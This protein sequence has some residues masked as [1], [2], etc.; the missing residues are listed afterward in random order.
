M[1][2]KWGIIGCGKISHDFVSSLSSLPKGEHQVVACAARKQESAQDFANSHEITRA[3]GSYEE[4][5]KDAE[6]QVVYIGAINPQHKDLAKLAISAG[7]GA[8]CE[9]PLCINLKETQEL[10]DLAR[11]KK[12][13]LMEGIWSRFFP[14][15]L[16]LK[17]L[18]SSGVI[19]DILQ[20]SAI[21]GTLLDQKDR[22][23]L[24]EMGG[25]TILD[26]GIYNVQFATLI[27]GTEKPEK[28]VAGGHLNSD[29]VDE[30]TSATL[31][32]K[33]GRTATLVTHGRVRL[34]NEAH[35]VGTKGTIK[36]PMRFW[37]PTEL[38]TPS[39]IEKFELPSSDKTFNYSNSVGLCYEADEVR[40][41]MQAGRIESSLMTLDESLAMAGIMED[42]RKQ[43]GV[44]YP[45]DD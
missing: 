11:Q 15:Y 44:V 9:K 4:L 20:V 25:G 23:R 41:C 26:I 6:V 12:V 13:F 21:F 17:E 8:L 29:G 1:S 27:F 19:G 31:V 43:V 42:I 38:E 35:V 3:Y 2:L 36:V 45:Q 32:Y 18:L 14:S 5:V 37:C 24:K 7:K 40:K 10:V 28:I 30:S 16:R 22:C 34:P 33:N 39:G